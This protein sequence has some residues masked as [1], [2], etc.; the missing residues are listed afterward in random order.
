M[1][2]QLNQRLVSLDAFRGF[3]IAGMII[4]NT[5]G[6]W[7]HVYGP[8]LHAN[9]HGVT[10]TD[11]VFPFFLF[12]VGV[13]IAL[14]YTKRIRAG[15][16][17]LSMIRKLLKRSAIIFLL[18]VFLWIK[19]MLNYSDHVV[20]E[21][22]QRLLVLFLVCAFLF[23]SDDWKKQAII[24]LLLIGIVLWLFPDGK[25]ADIRIPGVLQRI[26]LVFLACSLLFVRTNWKTQLWVGIGLLIGYWLIMVLLPVPI[27]EVIQQALVSGQVKAQSGMLDIGPIRAISDHY[28]AANLEPGTNL[29]AWLDRQLIP[30]RKWQ[31]TWD[32][33]GLLSTLPAIA[34]GISG[35]LVGKLIIEEK[36]IHKKI[37]WIFFFGILMYTL[38]GVWKWFFPFNK[39]LW[40]SSFVLHTSGLAAMTL[41]A[42]M[43]IIDV[44][45]WAKWSV[46]GRVFGAN[47]ITAYVLSGMLIFLFYG[48]VMGM[49]KLNTLFMDGL[50]AIG[51]SAKLASFLYAL[52]YM[53]I[54]FIPVYILYRKRIFIKI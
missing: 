13:S 21:F 17:T 25:L 49:P 27:D 41:A 29:Q 44:K 37:S 14:A 45:A 54:V 9:W 43:L 35:M 39:N 38:G 11:Y 6:S 40:S 33:E 23:Y 26:A 48:S 4:V 19:G 51:A 53:L 32:P 12:I 31:H 5:P 2:K 47:S 30:G 3:T 34:S 20:W 8:L 36:D 15:I 1:T 50:I 18:G 22:L 28:I 52:I 16:D 7:S 46:L 42:M 10:P 24:S